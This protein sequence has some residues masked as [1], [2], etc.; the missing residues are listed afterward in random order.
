MSGDAVYRAQ[1]EKEE[2]ESVDFVCWHVVDGPA[3]QHVFIDSASLSGLADLSNYTGMHIHNGQHA[4]ITTARFYLQGY[5]GPPFTPEHLIFEPCEH[6][7]FIGVDRDWTV[8]HGLASEG[9]QRAFATRWRESEE[10]LRDSEALVFLEPGE[11]VRFALW[12]DL[13]ISNREA[14]CYF[15]ALS[16]ESGSSERFS[17]AKYPLDLS[18]V[19]TVH[20]PSAYATAVRRTL[21]R[22][23]DL[24]RPD[25]AA[26]LI[27]GILPL[28]TL[29]RGT[30]GIPLG[31]R[32][33][34]KGLPGS[35]KTTLALEIAEAAAC[36]G[37]FAVWLAIDEP[38]ERVAVRRL[39]RLGLSPGEAQE[40]PRTG[41]ARLN[42]D[43]MVCGD[44]PLEEIW[45][46]AYEAASGN[47][48]V[49]VADS[50]QQVSANAG[51]GKGER[52]RIDAVLAAVKDC[53][54]RW[55]ATFVC[56]S[57]QARGSGEAK[58]SVGIDYAATTL[59]ALSR[60]GTR[61][62]VSV[63]KN[64]DGSEDGFALKL[65]AD[66]Q[67]VRAEGAPT[68]TD[69]IWSEVTKA[70][71]EHGPLSRTGLETWVTGGSAILR[72]TLRERVASGELTH[73]GKRYSLR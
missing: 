46:A 44:E 34:L 66:R 48:L 4:D 30:P 22:A 61:I 12:A 20:L 7:W 15:E 9:A 10:S 21:P 28:D 59:L 17:A 27:T 37:W 51:V 72:S 13:A 8:P 56:T 57:E 19:E 58:G 45:E 14:F 6:R 3:K 32:V 5:G 71:A 53:Q 63:K 54:R 18:C 43:L 23:V 2:A 33:V 60:T 24:A 62:A 31:A 35:C 39:Q 55:P 26:R 42:D 73:D 29:F 11:R 64:R 25:P 50:L 67:R 69:G 36:G 41:L 38:K 1:Q 40:L 52:E 68:V 49:V 47:P 16:S 65:D 70:L